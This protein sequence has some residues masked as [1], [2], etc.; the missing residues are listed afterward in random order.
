MTKNTTATLAMTLLLAACG[1]DG[2][3]SSGAGGGGGTG[4]SS[5]G[6]PSIAD[7]GVGGTPVGGTP[8]G[9]A[10][11]GGA[12]VGGMEPPPPVETPVEERCPDAQLGRYLLVGFPDRVDAYRQ[13]EFGATYFCKFLDLAGNGLS[14]ATDFAR[15]GEPGSPFFVTRTRDGRGEVHTFS[16]DGRYVGRTES[17][18]NLA[19][20]SRIWPKPG[21]GGFIAWARANSNLY[22]LSAEGTFVGPWEPPGWQGALVRDL[23]NLLFIRQDAAI[24]TFTVAPPRVFINPFFIDLPSE[25]IN[26]ANAIAGVDTPEGKKLLITAEVSGAGNGFGVVLY[27]PVISQLAPPEREDVLVEPGEIKDGISI[28]PLSS[29]FLVL[30]SAVGGAAAITS[31]NGEGMLQEQI[32]LTGAGNPYRMIFE[33]VFPSF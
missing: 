23:T 1:G 6:A 2:G 10:P 25:Q 27:K 22:E 30:D 11:I 32:G 17:N 31:F 29:G 16:P 15:G 4:G 3:S 21:G 8:V 5:G 13:R 33:Q 18:I 20:I 12:P 26:A 19:G 28:L 24:A 9:G 14:D 7:L